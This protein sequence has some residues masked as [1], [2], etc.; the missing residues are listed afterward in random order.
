ME[1]SRL[2]TYGEQVRVIVQWSK[3]T[4]APKR[5]WDG[6]CKAQDAKT[7]SIKEAE[8]L[9]RMERIFKEIEKHKLL[10]SL[11]VPLEELYWW[12]ALKKQGG[13]D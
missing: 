6:I 10:T 8:C 4:T 2:L 13:I 5:A 1:V 12:Q 11:A 7:A 3:E 9:V